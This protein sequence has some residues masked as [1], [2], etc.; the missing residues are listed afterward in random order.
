MN[1]RFSVH[2]SDKTSPR[3]FPWIWFLRIAQAVIS[4]VVLGLAATHI[5]TLNDLGC[6]VPGKMA[7]NLACVRLPLPLSCSFLVRS[8]LLC[9]FHHETF[10]SP[11]FL[12]V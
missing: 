1:P 6:S 4:L 2:T 9:K 11:S 10:S 8:V 7:W 12:I 5:S 3:G